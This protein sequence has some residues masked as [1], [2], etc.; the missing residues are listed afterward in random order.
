MGFQDLGKYLFV[1]IDENR[2]VGSVYYKYGRIRLV[3]RKGP[4]VFFHVKTIYYIVP[5]SQT[6]NITT[7]EF[8]AKIKG[9]S[10]KEAQKLIKEKAPNIQLLEDVQ[11]PIDAYA[12]R[13]YEVYFSNSGKV[14]GVHL[15]RGVPQR[16]PDFGATSSLFSDDIFKIANSNNGRDIFE[17]NVLVYGCFRGY[18]DMRRN[19]PFDIHS[20]YEPDCLP[21]FMEEEL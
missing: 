10:Q 21:D 16:F 5:K 6:R 18:Y 15:S 9:L 1:S 2:K 12:Y 4:F 17:K 7:E 19:V 13:L 14:T 8:R 11:Q 3:H 20:P